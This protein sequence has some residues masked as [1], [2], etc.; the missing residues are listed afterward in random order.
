MTVDVADEKADRPEAGSRAVV[1]LQARRRV[2]LNRGVIIG[3]V[4]A[5][6]ALERPRWMDTKSK[7]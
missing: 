4:R 3:A 7:P 6:G 5:P 2:V 1:R